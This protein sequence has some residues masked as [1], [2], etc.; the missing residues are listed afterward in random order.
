MF[1][2]TISISYLTTEHVKFSTA[3]VQI[4]ENLREESEISSQ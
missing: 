3:Y 2:I 1:I 4:F